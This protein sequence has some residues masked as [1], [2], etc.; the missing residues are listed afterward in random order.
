MAKKFRSP[1]LGV[2]FSHIYHFKLSKN[3]ND[4]NGSNE[5]DI[6]IY[7][8]TTKDMLL[9]SLLVGAIVFIASLPSTGIPTI[10]NLYSAIRGFLYYF[11]AQLIVD[12]VTYS[13]AKQVKKAEGEKK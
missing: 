9:D 3:P 4:G 7:R 12:R 8:K 11:L 5:K 2:F 13:V 1:K 6:Y 10:D